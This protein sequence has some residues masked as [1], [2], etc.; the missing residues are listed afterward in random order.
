VRPIK[1]PNKIIIIIIIIISGSSGSSSSI[2]S[3]SSSSSSSSISSTRRFVARSS[4]WSLQSRNSQHAYA[5]VR[6]TQT[7]FT[8]SSTAV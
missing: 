8:N 1:S 4:Q 3:S 5:K 7:A 6:V 2:S